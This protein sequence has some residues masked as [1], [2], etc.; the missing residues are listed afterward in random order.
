MIVVFGESGADAK[1]SPTDRRVV[2]YA[3]TDSPQNI[4][5]AT[6]DR[7]RGLSAVWTRKGVLFTETH[8]ASMVATR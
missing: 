1:P 6:L 8:G 7:G 2:L 4:V 5:R 3:T